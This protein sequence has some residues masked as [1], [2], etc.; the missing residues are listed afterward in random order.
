MFAKHDL[1]QTFQ[2]HVGSSCPS[3]EFTFP[4]H[5]RLVP[6]AV[7]R[8]GQGGEEEEEQVRTRVRL[9]AG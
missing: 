8:N 7:L 6:A 1:L 5:P 9:E 2:V 4:L 3:R